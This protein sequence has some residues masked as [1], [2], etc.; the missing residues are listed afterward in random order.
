MIAQ[1]DFI[2][3]I[4][5]DNPQAFREFER[6]GARCTY[7]SNEELHKFLADPLNYKAAE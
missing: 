2:Y 7:Y 1:Q 4:N 5:L 6:M 3:L